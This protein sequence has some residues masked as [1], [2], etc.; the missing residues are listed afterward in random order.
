LVPQ[1]PHRVL[2]PPEGVL[3]QRFTLAFFFRPSAD[4]VLQLPDS[5]A[6]R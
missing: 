3:T 4:A 2:C 5:D 1:T 6:N